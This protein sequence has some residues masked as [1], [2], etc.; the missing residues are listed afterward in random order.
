MER[1]GATTIKEV[2]YQAGYSYQ[3]T[4]SWCPTGSAL[5]KRKEGVVIVTDPDL[6]EKK[7]HR[8]SVHLSR[9]LGTASVVSGRGRTISNNPS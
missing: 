6:E 4:R 7:V 2:L 1:I 8:A 3:R 9:R 5:R